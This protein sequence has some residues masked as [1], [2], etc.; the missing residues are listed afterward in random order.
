MNTKTNT[1]LRHFLRPGP[2]VVAATLA[3]GGCALPLP[4]TVASLVAD[5]IS[6]ATTEKSLTDH[7]ISALTEQDCAVHRAFTDEKGEICRAEIQAITV[8]AFEPA[9]AP[10]A[11]DEPIA[12][13]YL[14]FASS[15]DLGTANQMRTMLKDT[16]T[17][18]FAEPSAPSPMYHVVGGPI[19]RQQYVSSQAYANARGYAGAWAIKIEPKNWQTSS[20]IIAAVSPTRIDAVEVSQ[21]ALASRALR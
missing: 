12:G 3:L 6:Y 5:G 1:Y 4:L 10:P 14:V 18:V 11:A 8:A 7:G 16:Q 21:P 15:T 20:R 9:S 2:L 13:V 19:S 17:E